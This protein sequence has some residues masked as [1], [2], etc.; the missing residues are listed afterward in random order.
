MLT[1]RDV[2]PPQAA[3]VFD[4]IFLRLPRRAG[5]SWLLAALFTLACLTA[6]ASHAQTLAITFDDGFD[7]ANGNAQAVDDN[8]AMLAALK[9][10]RVRAMLFPAGFIAERPE[11][12]ALVREWGK[13]G[14]AI[15]NHTYSHEALSK[16]DTGQ[17]LADILQAHKLLHTLPGWCPRLRF[18][19]LD[20]G[21]GQAQHG[22]AIQWL[23]WH[24]YGVAPVTIALR[25][26]EDAQRYQEILKTGSNEDAAAFRRHYVE[27]VGQQA[28]A[29]EAYW[30]GEIKRSPAH[31]LLLHANHLNAAALPD[32]LQWFDRHGWTFIDPLSAFADPIYQR[33]YTDENGAPAALPTP[34]CR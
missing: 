14:H 10:Y 4:S 13:A 32:L 26:W 19:F 9:R 3:M 25:D 6:A 15:G 28:Q 22:Q 17:Y 2:I 1:L 31:V 7:A 18:P 27:R 34:A 11:N 21:G 12:M 16:S 29:Q 8:A 30:Q 24:G 20:E 33:G 23:A 5:G